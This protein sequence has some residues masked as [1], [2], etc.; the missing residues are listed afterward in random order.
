MDPAAVLLEQASC[1]ALRHS[2]ATHPLE[3]GDD[4]RTVQELLGHTGVRR[5]RTYT[6]VVNRGGLGWTWQTWAVLQLLQIR[7]RAV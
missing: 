6:D 3:G 2:L 5:T 4:S 1:R 7:E